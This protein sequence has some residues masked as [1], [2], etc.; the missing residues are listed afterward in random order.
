MSSR[1]SSAGSAKSG[2]E[3]SGERA[4]SNNNHHRHLPQTPKSDYDEFDYDSARTSSKE[5]RFE[6][7]RNMNNNQLPPFDSDHCVAGPSPQTTNQLHA[8]ASRIK[9]PLTPKIVVRKFR[10]LDA[11]ELTGSPA[12]DVKIGQRVAYKEYYG[13]EFGTIR[14]IG[15][16]RNH[17]E[18]CSLHWS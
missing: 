6:L 15:E 14:W 8:G 2:A 3:A 16:L 13:N 4:S 10:K 1:D 17:G 7:T 18:L 11:N 12:P 5:N 9:D